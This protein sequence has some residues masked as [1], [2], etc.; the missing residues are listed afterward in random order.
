ANLARDVSQQ[1]YAEAQSV[2]YDK[3]LQEGVMSK[4]QAEQ[5]HT[6][7]DAK[8]EAVKADQAA[9]ESARASLLADQAMLDNTNVQLSYTSIRSPI[10]G[11]TGNL[12]IKQGNLIKAN[13]IDLVTI[14]QIKPIYVT[15]S[16]PE[17][18]LTNI[19]QR[20]AQGKLTVAAVPQGTAVTEEAAEHGVLTFMDNS[21]DQTTGT[22]KLKGTFSNED[23]K[24]WPGQFIKVT[25]RLNTLP[26][27]LIV[28]TQAVQTGQD[29]QFVYV[30]K[31][32]MSVEAR[33]V[34]TGMRVDQDMVIETG[35]RPGES[36]V[37]EG[38]LRLAPG[39]KVQTRQ[40][41]GSQQQRRQRPE[42]KK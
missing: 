36:I 18:Q 34:T 37:T 22:I 31:D 38:Q 9:I 23:G 17:G 1:R 19:K 2:R 7:A 21:V 41:G 39:M 3:L 15:F 5:I 32:D 10:D 16:V 30:V 20:M 11:R 6:D 27:A 40:L 42:K 13:D 29:G 4:E 8:K 25:L 33:P 12:A 28:P 14:N 35:L 24:L 26:D